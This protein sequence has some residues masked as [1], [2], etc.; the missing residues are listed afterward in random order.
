GLFARALIAAVLTRVVVTCRVGGLFARAL[1]AA[2][3]ARVVVTCRV[4]AHRVGGHF[5][6]TRVS[7]VIG[8]VFPILA[9]L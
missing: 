8:L 6:A 3:L 9:R 5:Q 2:V 4:G 1:I 7:R